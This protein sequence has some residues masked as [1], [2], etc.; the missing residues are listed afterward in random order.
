M[1]ATT[2]R[3][4][5]MVA[6]AIKATD[7]DGIDRSLLIDKLSVEFSS[8]NPRF[9]RDRFTKACTPKVEPLALVPDDKTEDEPYEFPDWWTGHKVE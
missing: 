3:V 7:M 1:S 2:A 9:D 4:Y 8:D 5:V 6:R